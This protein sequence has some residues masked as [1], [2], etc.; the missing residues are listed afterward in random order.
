MKFLVSADL[1]LGRSSSG[2]A[3]P[4][5]ERSSSAAWYSMVDY[6]VKHSV[7]G[8]LLAGDIIDKDNRYFEALPVLRRGFEQL[9][10][11]GI[12]V[13][14][15]AGNHDFDVLPAVMNQGG[16]D[17]VHFLGP[18]GKW[19]CLTLDVKGE[20]VRF[21]GWSFPERYFRSS[22]LD[23]PD[24]AVA[25]PPLPSIPTIGLLHC[26]VGV[27]DS[28][29][30]PVPATAFDRTVAD[31][32]VLGHIHKPGVLRE[33]PICIYP[34]SPQPLSAK[35]TG[36]HGAWVLTLYEGAFSVEP[37]TTSAIRFE[38]VQVDVKDSNTAVMLF[39]TVTSA[40]QDFIIGISSGGEHLSELV[41]D[42]V[43]IGESQNPLNIK[44]W[45]DSFDHTEINGV[46][47]T[48]R[49]VSDHGVTAPLDLNALSME[50]SPA[51]I[52]ATAILDIQ[53]GRDSVFIQ[54]LRAELGSEFLRLNRGTAYINTTDEQGF[55]TVQPDN[56]VEVDRFIATHCRQLLIQMIAGRNG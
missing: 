7:D 50:N 40:I 16:G 53:H 10:D 30:A 55:T 43:M 9:K 37:V 44:I 52:L 22:P 14:M 11:A 48:M 51:G 42:L 29:Y 36:W 38:T 13:I 6:A 26:D 47:V 5:Y 24:L 41:V 32:W 31:V 19:S 17:G 12:P 35:E 28:P 2:S 20:S 33:H 18:G 3:L 34:G 15:T 49:S 27:P 23:L 45:S 4:D 8:V 21:V 39:E 46:K 54:N 1:H 25:A 56:H